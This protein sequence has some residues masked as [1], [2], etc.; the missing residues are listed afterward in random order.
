M[1]L[2]VS[3]CIEGSKRFPYVPVEYSPKIKAALI[4]DSALIITLLT[5]GIL[6]I[7][8]SGMAAGHSLHAIGTI[9]KAW[10]G[11]M[12]GLAAFITLADLL[13]HNVCTGFE[14]LL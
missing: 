11:T 3:L 13:F 6:A 4:F 14:P 7:I 10:G 2:T 9:G 5:V 12:L 8:G 1:A